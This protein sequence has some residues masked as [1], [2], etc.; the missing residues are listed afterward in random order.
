MPQGSGQTIPIID[1]GHILRSVGRLALDRLGYRT[2][3]AVK[4][5]DGAA[6]R[7][8]RAR[9]LSLSAG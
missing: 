8:L 6:S 3:L 9:A 2:K 1:D 7:A 5:A 4:G